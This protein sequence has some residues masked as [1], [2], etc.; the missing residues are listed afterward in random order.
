M[1]TAV[2]A[3]KDNLEMTTRF[4]ERFL[5]TFSIPLSI[6]C[7][8]SNQE[9]VKY[10]KGLQEAYPQITVVS[11]NREGNISFSENFNAA[12]NAV[13]TEKMVVVHNDM[14]FQELFFDN[15]EKHLTNPKEFLLYTTIEEQ[16]P[17][18]DH[19]RPGKVTC[20]SIPKTVIDLDRLAIPL[21]NKAPEKRKRAYGFFLAGYTESFHAVGGY[22]QETFN[23]CYCEDD[24]FM[25][26]LREKGFYVTWDETAICFHHS[27]GTTKQVDQSKENVDLIS[28]RRFVRKWGFEVRYLWKTKYEEVDSFRVSDRSIALLDK[29]G[30]M[31][32]MINV[33]PIFQEIVI[34]EDQVS[35]A[36]EIIQKAAETFPDCLHCIAK[37]RSSNQELTS[38]ILI[39]REFESKGTSEEFQQLTELIGDLRIGLGTKVFKQGT[40]FAVGPYTILIL[41][42]DVPGV[43][44]DSKNY[45]SLQ[46]N[47]KYNNE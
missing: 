33:E 18:D 39:I 36:K 16:Q 24:D 26:R 47:I 2:L 4:L 31:N 43:L 32:F 11:G 38:S 9:T 10:L 6:S 22:D 3:V 35:R 37:L 45:L 23:P 5:G 42:S 21:M 27:K 20:T 40:K 34:A 17:G 15:L 25:V 30:E 12:I 7:L 1:I 19:T 44:E 29:T 14:S 13:K 46:Q 8:G 28:N 41:K